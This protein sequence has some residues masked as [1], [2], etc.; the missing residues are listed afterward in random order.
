MSS[1]I[2]WTDETQALVGT[3]TLAVSTDGKPVRFTTKAFIVP[4]LRL[5]MAGLGLAGFLGR[6]FVQMNDFMLV[7][8]IE[9]LD[10]HTP[11]ILAANWER[12]KQEF[13]A[14]DAGRT[15]T[16]YHFG[17]S[18]S[19]GKIRSFAYRST[20]NFRSEEIRY[21][22]GCKPEC[23]VLDNEDYPRAFRRMMD[24]QRAIQASRP[25]EER[26]Y[27]GGE[28]IVHHLTKD[29]FATYTLGRFDD[30]ANDEAAMYE[31][32]RVAKNKPTA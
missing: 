16:V 26:L 20:N 7:K 4:H 17:F 21:A 32:F 30:Y 5:L 22:L 12:V 29:G 24:E 6:W 1:L 11:A 10:D 18:E 9:H 3:D 27:I 15:T 31:N 2:F 14:A 28:I 13:P 23:T 19:T 8:G 25:K